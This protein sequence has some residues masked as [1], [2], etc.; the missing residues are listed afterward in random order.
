MNVIDSDS[1]VRRA[2]SRHPSCQLPSAPPTVS[3]R[4]T[5]VGRYSCTETAAAGPRVFGIIMNPL[6]LGHCHMVKPCTLCPAIGSFDYIASISMCSPLP[7]SR[8]SNESVHL[9]VML[10][11]LLLLGI[12]GTRP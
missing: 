9:S 10:A 12:A 3:E 2:L 6:T 7:E 5:Q 11:Q 4:C 8:D 1:S